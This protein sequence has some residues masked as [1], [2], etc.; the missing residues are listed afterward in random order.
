MLLT[1]HPNMQADP[2]GL[3]EVINTS[4]VSTSTDL[5]LGQSIISPV[6]GSPAVATTDGK[7]TNF[8]LHLFGKGSP[9]EFL[10][11]DID[12]AS[13]HLDPEAKLSFNVEIT[14]VTPMGPLTFVQ[15]LTKLLPGN[16]V[17]FTIKITDGGVEAGTSLPIPTINVGYIAISNMKFGMAVTLPFDGSALR[18]RW[19][20]SSKD[21]PFTLTICLFGGGGWL[22]LCLGADGV[23]SLTIGFVFGAM[24]ELDLGV[25][26]GGAY[27]QFGIILVLKV[28]ESPT[29]GQETDL[30]GFVRAGGALEFFGMVSITVEL[31]I[32]L[33]YKD[34][35]KAYG[36]A[37]FT[38]S[39]AISVLSMTFEFEAERELAGAGAD[40]GFA[41]QISPADWSAY[42]GAFSA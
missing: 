4:L 35:G 16:D 26:S 14:G 37:K 10:V 11:L 30:T 39:V 9:S 22:E 36:K 29:K 40:P 6:D 38:I 42:C 25:A 1:W 32:A 19:S 17:G 34:P 23:E 13:F 21:D 31:Y 41:D 15:E 7:L 28:A 3:L 20:F 5:T 18:M 33:T 12:E 2:L 8:K 27:I 24:A